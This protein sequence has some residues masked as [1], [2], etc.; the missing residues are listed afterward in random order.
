MTFNERKI[1]QK[2]MRALQFFQV[3]GKKWIFQGSKE[4]STFARSNQFN[5]NK[6]RKA[7]TNITV[8]EHVHCK[9][10]YVEFALCAHIDNN[11]KREYHPM[12]VHASIDGCIINN[13][14]NRISTTKFK[15][16]THCDHIRWAEWWHLRM[17]LWRWISGESWEN[18]VMSSH[19]LHIIKFY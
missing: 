12:D 5:Y 6:R 10:E 16:I 1:K 7:F 3:Y 14:T 11:I 8:S 19:L 2:L 17:S 13:N 18:G 15:W 4:S 9:W